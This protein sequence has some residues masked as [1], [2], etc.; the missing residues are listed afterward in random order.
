MTA[1]ALTGPGP[2]VALERSAPWPVDSGDD[3]GKQWGDPYLDCTLRVGEQ[4][5]YHTSTWGDMCTVWLAELDT[6][7]H[8]TGVYEA[9]D[10]IV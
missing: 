6:V 4:K 8:T 3:R 7:V 5:L 10:Q 1:K 9:S 2:L